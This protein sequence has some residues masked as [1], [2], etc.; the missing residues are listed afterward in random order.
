ME[1][2]LTRLLGALSLEGEELD[3]VFVPDIAYDQVEERFQFSLVAKVLTKQ[4]F[5]IQTLKDTLRNLWGGEDGVQV[6]GMGVNLFHVIIVEESRMMRVLQH[7]LWLFEGYAILLKNADF[8]RAIGAHIR[9][10]I[11]VDKRSIEQEWGHYIRVK[12]HGDRNLR[13]EVVGNSE[14]F[15]PSMGNRGIR[16]RSYD[17]GVEDNND[18]H[19]FKGTKPTSGGG[20]GDGETRLEHLYGDTHRR[21]RPTS[22]PIVSCEEDNT[23]DDYQFTFATGVL[24]EVQGECLVVG[25]DTTNQLF[26]SKGV[27]I[28]K[29]LQIGW[30]QPSPSGPRLLDEDCDV[31]LSRHWQVLHSSSG[32]G[33]IVDPV[34]IA[35]GITLMWKDPSL[36]TVEREAEW[37]V[38]ILVKDESK[39]P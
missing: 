36:V 35:G 18:D 5:H 3:E 28:T 19:Q 15:E 21:E 14:D 27:D 12:Q 31:E 10:V 39:R 24:H 16:I 20:L 2:D 11:E 26:P 17:R 34:G 23:G 13:N 9:E 22:P 33:Y 7:E 32:E 1:A 38:E 29:L 8:G 6:L 30:R 25:I 4:H 37:W